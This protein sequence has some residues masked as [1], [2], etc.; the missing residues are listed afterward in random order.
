[1]KKK[2]IFFNLN[3]KKILEV[4]LWLA[5]EKPGITFHTAVKVLFFADIEHLNKYGRPITGDNWCA[6]QYGPVPSYTY[7]LLKER[8]DI[9]EAIQEDSMPFCIEKNGTKPCIYA[10]RKAETEYLSDTDI[11]ELKCSL[12]K[13]GNLSFEKLTDISHKHRAWKEAWASRINDSGPIKYE[14]MIE[15]DEM[16]KYVTELCRGM[17]F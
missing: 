5:N 17:Q 15:D 4:V 10:K 13:Y 6:L 2:S 3:S 1:M 7:D 16:R 8:P 12:E 11:E 9:V 14:L